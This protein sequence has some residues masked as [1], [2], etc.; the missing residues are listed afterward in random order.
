LEP[1]ENALDSSARQ[2]PV[3]YD[4]SVQQGVTETGV[5]LHKL[6]MADALKDE[7]DEEQV[8]LPTRE[9]ISF[10]PKALSHKSEVVDDLP[11]M[12][13]L[14]VAV[15]RII[16]RWILCMKFNSIIEAYIFNLLMISLLLCRSVI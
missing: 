3:I 14:P 15:M 16:L 5:L 13:C 8:S 2:L 1:K 6:C 12:A 9:L 4:I 10:C 11:A 7:Q